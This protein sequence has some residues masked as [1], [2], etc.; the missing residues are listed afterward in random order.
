MLN[1][2]SVIGCVY[3]DTLDFS[4]LSSMDSGLYRIP[5]ILLRKAYF[6]H[7]LVMYGW[8]FSYWMGD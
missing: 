5:Q 7:H 3:A 6:W 8:T 1:G 4:R 2:K